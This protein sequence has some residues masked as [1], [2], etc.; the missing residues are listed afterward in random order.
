MITFSTYPATLFEGTVK[1]LLYALLPA[2]LVGYLTVEAL[3]SLSSGDAALAVAGSAA[4]LVLGAC[5]F[6]V[7][8]TRYES[9]NLMEMPG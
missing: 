4:I 3:R 9:G 6:Y 2:A 1:L 8:L 5:V 7:G